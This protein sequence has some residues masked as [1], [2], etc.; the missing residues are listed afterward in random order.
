M[1]HSVKLKAGDT[2]PKIEA[3]LLDGSVVTLGKPQEQGAWQAVFVY[4]GKHCP[5]CTKYLNEVESYKQAFLDAGVEVLAV[6]ADSKQQLQEHVTQLDVSFPIAYGLSEQQ[7]KE[8]GVYI[9]VPR[10]EQETDHNFSEP[11]LFVVNENGE[12]HV[13]DLSNNPFI[14]PELGALT[15]GLAWIRDPNNHY[16]IRGTLDY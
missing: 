11:G 14:R 4:R 2:F 12:L 10:S 6:S 5:L 7:M 1:A 16:P 8:L 13:V 15:R 9:S 3:T